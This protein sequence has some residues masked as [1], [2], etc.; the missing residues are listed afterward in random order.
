[1]IRSVVFNPSQSDQ[2]QLHAWGHRHAID[3]AKRVGK[4]IRKVLG[5]G[6]LDTFGAACSSDDIYRSAS[7][8]NAHNERGSTG[9]CDKN[10]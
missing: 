3:I 10:S 1:M 9:P 6:A 2:L 4:N 8:E 5:P 7:D